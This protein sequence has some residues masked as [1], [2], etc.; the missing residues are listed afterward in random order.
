MPCPKRA[1]GTYPLL[2]ASP[3]DSAE[4]SI[5]SIPGRKV[6]E[7]TIA[8]A[9]SIPERRK[10][11]KIPFFVGCPLNIEHPRTAAP[12]AQ[13]SKQPLPLTYQK[14]RNPRTG[15][16]VVASAMTLGSV[17][18]AR[19]LGRSVRQGENESGFNDQLK[20]LRVNRQSSRFC[21]QQML[22][23]LLGLT[24]QD[25]DASKQY[26]PGALRDLSPQPP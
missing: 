8:L 3:Q 12:P 6:W 21:E 13:L 17:A 7:E 23:C 1:E 11:D 22:I 24:R 25:A 4:D 14:M 15:S 19:T 18:I 26:L 9:F 10:L 16:V 20:C 5:D 2:P